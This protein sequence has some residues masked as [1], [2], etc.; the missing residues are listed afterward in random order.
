MPGEYQRSLVPALL[1]RSGG[2]LALTVDFC[3]RYGVGE[4]LPS[5]LYVEMQL[6][7]PCTS[8][9]DRTYQVRPTVSTLL[10]LIPLHPY[11]A[12]KDQPLGRY[13]DAPLVNRRAFQFERATRGPHAGRELSHAPE[14]FDPTEEKYFELLPREKGE[15]TR[16]NAP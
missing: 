15:E 1:E 10:W 6:S 16:R 13:G 7:L 14:S 8:P 2:D 5:L 12:W 3:E 11:F 9:L 4:G